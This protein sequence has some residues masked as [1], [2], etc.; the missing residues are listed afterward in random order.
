MA[1][2][3]ICSDFG[4]PKIKSITVSIISPFICHE[5]VGLDTM[6]VVFWMKSFKPAFSLSSFTYIKK[7]FSS[8]SLSAIRVVSF[9]YL[10]L[11]IFLPAILVQLV[12]HPVQHFAWCTFHVSLLS[13]VQYTALTYV[14]CWNQFIL[15][16]PFLTVASWPA[17]MFLRRHVRWSVSPI[18]F[19]IFHSVLW[20]TQSKA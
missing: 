16:C 8:P 14:P 6:I 7:L 18:S 1:V 15:S 9:A 10:R 17:Y 19:R 13:R 4:A 3:T 12:L 11:L 20:Y 5:V 2:V